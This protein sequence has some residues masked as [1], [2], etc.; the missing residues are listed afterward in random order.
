MSNPDYVQE[1]L[2][3][4][5]NWDTN[6]FSPKPRLIDGDEMRDDDTGNRARNADVIDENIITVT[7]EPTT[8]NEPIGTEFDYRHE[9]GA[10]MRIEG[11]HVDGGGQLAD[12]DEFNSLITEARRLV[13]ANRTFPVSDDTWLEL[14]DENDNSSQ[15]GDAHY[16]VW[17]ADVIFHGFEDLA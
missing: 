9:A 10:T 8:Q 12:K 7:S 4:L 16:F 5:Q 13:H 15:Q 3:Y 2:D 1:V 17:T 14:R 11:Y 6:N